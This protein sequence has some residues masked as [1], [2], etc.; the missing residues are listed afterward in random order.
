[1]RYPSTAG[2]A[3]PGQLVPCAHGGSASACAVHS[4]RLVSVDICADGVPSLP[5]LLQG[6]VRDTYELDDKIVIV[7]TDR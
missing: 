1:M 3:T 7:T 6:K 2:K 4:W 5:P